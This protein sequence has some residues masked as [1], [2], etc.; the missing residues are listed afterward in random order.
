MPAVVGVCGLGDV[1]NG[2][3][4]GR[5]H[6]VTQAEKRDSNRAGTKKLDHEHPPYAKQSTWLVT[7]AATGRDPRGLC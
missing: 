5:G 1:G 6:P 2:Q 3:R 7:T 4:V